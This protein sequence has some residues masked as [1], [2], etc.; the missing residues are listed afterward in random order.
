MQVRPAGPPAPVAEVHRPVEAQG[1]E[2]FWE[3]SPVVFRVVWCALFVLNVSI[4]TYVLGLGLGYVALTYIGSISYYAGMFRLITLDAFPV[5]IAGY[6][7]VAAVYYVRAAQFVLCSVR[8]RRLMFPSS[9]P[10]GRVQPASSKKLRVKRDDS[11]P[12]ALPAWSALHRGLHRLRGIYK[13]CSVRG[14]FFEPMIMVRE[15]V[16]VAIQTWQ[17]FVFSRQSAKV[18]VNAVSVALIVVNCYSSPMLRRVFM[19]STPPAAGRYRATVLCVDLALDLVWFV[20]IPV[21]LWMPYFDELLRGGLVLYHDTFIIQ[22][23]M[24]LP[25]MLATSNVDVLLK[26]WPAVSTYF[27]VQKIELLTRQRHGGGS[28]FDRSRSQSESASPAS[29]ASRTRVRI[30]TWLR[31]LLLCWGHIVATVYVYANFINTPECG[32]DC[33]LALRPWFRA[34]GSCECAALR[35]DCSRLRIGGSASE[36]ERALQ[37]IAP[38]ALMNLVVAHCPALHVPAALSALRGLYGLTIFNCSIAAWDPSAPISSTSHPNMGRVQLIHTFVSEIPQALLHAN[39]PPRLLEIDI[40]ASN[41]SRL[42]DDLFAHWPHVTTLLLDIGS[43]SEYPPVLGKMPALETISLFGNRIAHIPDDALQ[44]NSKLR[45]LMYIADVD[46]PL[47]S[48]A[49][50]MLAHVRVFGFGSPV[51]A[52]TTRPSWLVCEDRAFFYYGVESHAYYPLEAKLAEY[53]LG[54]E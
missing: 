8:H 13:L 38:N 6:L 29:P 3:V 43:F 39:L 2:V 10:H 26:L 15:V 14:E 42:P 19:P 46:T 4:A 9:A 31:H 27:G 33:Q 21:L 51:C 35:I 49:A 54:G 47:A 16:E 50:F 44:G 30:E 36:I 34:S 22:G 5:V 48:G 24:E 28:S 11:D 1:D 12:A 37:Q 20:A 18:W 23:V 45:F 40:V 7:A 41:L 53:P 25:V 32:A 52:V 17:A